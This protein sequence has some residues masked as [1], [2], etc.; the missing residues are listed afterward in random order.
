LVPWLRLGIPARRDP[1]LRLDVP[2][3]KL[4]AAVSHR[5]RQAYARQRTGT[6]FRRAAA[7]I[8]L[9]SI[10]QSP[11]SVAPT[12]RGPTIMNGDAKTRC[13]AED[14]EA[15]DNGHNMVCPPST[16]HAPV[17]GLP[18]RPLPRFKRVRQTKRRFRR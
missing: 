18:S 13:G 2:A 3:R 15:V 10:A 7:L 5:A 8:Q 1:R 4:S 6:G 12:H 9:Y 17:K 16:L 11:S 14:G